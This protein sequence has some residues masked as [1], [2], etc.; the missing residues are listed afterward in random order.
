MKNNYTKDNLKVAKLNK[1]VANLFLLEVNMRIFCSPDSDI[2][3]F[4]F[5]V[6]V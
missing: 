5:V 2:M 1:L 3:P 6:D 4:H